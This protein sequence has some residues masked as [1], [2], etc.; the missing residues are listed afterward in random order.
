M[1]AVIYDTATGGPNHNMLPFEMLYVMVA[2]SVPAALLALLTHWVVGM[3]V[4]PQ[5]A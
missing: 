5:G 3:R 4:R 1:T 2:T